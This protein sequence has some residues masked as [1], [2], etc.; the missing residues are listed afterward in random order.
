MNQ[1]LQI[2]TDK[3]LPVSADNERSPVVIIGSGPVGVRLLEELQTLDPSLPI[4]IY[5]DEPWTPY[6]RVR[7]SSLLAGEVK[8]S[9]IMLQPRLAEQARV[10]THYHCRVTGID[11][12]QQYVIDEAGNR[13]QYS[14]LVI[15]T[16][17]RPSVPSVPGIDLVGTY[18]FRDLD[19]V[20]KLIARRTRSNHVVVLGGGLL[21]L[22]S[23]RAM[24]RYGANVTVI[25]H[26]ERL[27]FRQLD[28]TSSGLILDKVRSLG[29]NVILGDGM[30]MAVGTGAVQSIVLRS[31]FETSCDTLIIATGIVPEITLARQAGIAYGRGIQVNEFLQTSDA[32]IY[33]VGECCEYQGEVYG[34]VAPGFE[35][36]MVAAR[37]I[38]ASRA[39]YQGSLLATSLKVVDYPVF[40]LGDINDSV[41]SYKQYSWH[42]GECYR[43]LNVSRGRII[44]IVAIGEWDEL[45]R[46]REAVKC[47][48]RFWPWQFKRFLHKGRLWQASGSQNVTSWPADSIICSCNG[49]TRK[50]LTDTI[51]GG[52]NSMASIGEKTAAGTVCGT[53]KPLL[54]E[55]LGGV[56]LD[57]VRAST[58]LLAVSVIALLVSLGALSL[59]GIPYVDSVQVAWRWDVLWT[60][61]L[62]KQISGFTLLGLSALTL[63]FS[64]R[65]RIKTIR[66]G[67]FDY[68]RL[69]HVVVGALALTALL[70]HSGF[71]L[72]DNLNFI[73]M[74]CFTLIL[75]S[76]TLIGSVIAM[77]HR[78]Q[79]ALVRQLKTS[80]F[81]IHILLFWPLPL[82]LGVHV[83]KTYYF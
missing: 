37:N 46:L 13:Q 79:P 51:A 31:G 18:T 60:T 23:A 16:G 67:H 76:G 59:P 6:N 72:G 75:L 10:V 15:A 56:T 73:L 63:F 78:L 17:S 36:A 14:K 30:R 39:R 12:A 81:W 32:D 27:M 55:L 11:R 82:L 48:Q 71:R 42:E 50:Q 22:E 43:R 74:L 7:L 4:V 49:V 21:G 69:A 35:Q 25:E 68:W 28:E 52:C 40:S 38:V 45:A 2:S 66:V 54:Q 61:S 83:F 1:A 57:P 65:K 80:G 9:D 41:H 70:V 77:E 24:Q 20:Q 29:I 34:L 19:D 33:A 5:G 47:R 58:F 8:Q 62:F 26:N 3:S 53:C 64:L 44:G